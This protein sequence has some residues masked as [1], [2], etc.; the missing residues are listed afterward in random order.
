[1]SKCD[2]SEAMQ[3]QARLTCTCTSPVAVND[4]TSQALGSQRER[5][6][7]G[8]EPSRP[9]QCTFVCGARTTVETAA[10]QPAR[11]PC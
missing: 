6:T 8:G 7:S 5:G 4:P 1:M 10:K 3:V 11:N 2:M 9:C